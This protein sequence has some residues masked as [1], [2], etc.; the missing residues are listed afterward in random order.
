MDIVIHNVRILT[1]DRDHPMVEEGFVGIRD[2]IFGFVSEVQPRIMARRFIDGAGKTFVPVGIAAGEGCIRADH[3]A[4][5]L[6]LRG[7]FAPETIGAAEL[8]DLVMILHNGVVIW[9]AP[10]KE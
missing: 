6:L 10:V 8:A 3:P 9:E 7:H 1:M 5:G 4:S 2:G